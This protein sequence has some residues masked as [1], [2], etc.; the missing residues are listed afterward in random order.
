MWA[1]RIWLFFLAIICITQYRASADEQFPHFGQSGFNETLSAVVEHQTSTKTALEMCINKYI[2]RNVKSQSD[3]M[4]LMTS[5]CLACPKERGEYNAAS[6][7]W[8]EFMDATNSNYHGE[9]D[10][11]INNTRSSRTCGALGLDYAVSMIKNK[12]HEEMEARSPALVEAMKS[13]LL[14]ALECNDKYVVLFSLET[15]ETPE[16]IA[17]TAFGKCDGLFEEAAEARNDPSYPVDMRDQSK[18]ELVKEMRRIAL[19]R[20]ITTVVEARARQRLAPSNPAN[21]QK[22]GRDKSE[23]PI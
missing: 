5:G 20:A 10:K 8:W 15:T 17:K 22:P 21:E 4:K 11:L 18:A 12:Q 16:N 7:T 1:V 3:A 23:S 2:H 19:E 13:K 14:L 6:A 9:N